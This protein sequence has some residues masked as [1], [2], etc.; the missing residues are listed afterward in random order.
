M[1]LHKTD[2]KGLQKLEIP[3]RVGKYDL[4]RTQSPENSFSTKNKI[5]ILRFYD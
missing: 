1:D 4:E 2:E 3:I 5:L